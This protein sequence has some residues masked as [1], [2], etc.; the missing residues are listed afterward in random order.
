MLSLIDAKTI[1]NTAAK[2]VLEEVMFSDKTPDD[3]VAEKGLSQISDTDAL[4]QIVADVLA[5]NP[6]AIEQYRGGK[7]N[8][9]GF[10]VGQ[11][12]RTTKGKGNPAVLSA[13][14]LEKIG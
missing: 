14:L 6:Q 3:V 4:R 2:A 5:A 7:T 9:L 1:S 13:L 10:L 8:V 11:C 12:M